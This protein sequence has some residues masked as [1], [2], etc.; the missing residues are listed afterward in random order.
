MKGLVDTYGYNGLSKD[1]FTVSAVDT[2]AFTSQ[3]PAI[4][5]SSSSTR[6]S[7]LPFPPTQ[8]IDNYG[9]YE[10]AYIVQD[11]SQA[12][13]GDILNREIV[14]ITDVQSYLKEELAAAYELISTSNMSHFWEEEA[15]DPQHLSRLVRT[16]DTTA[17]STLRNRFITEIHPDN[18][19]DNTSSEKKIS[20]EPTVVTASFQTPI[21]GATSGLNGS[22]TASLAWCIYLESM[23][24]NE[25]LN[26]DIKE[27][28]GNHPNSAIHA[29]WLP[30]FGPNPSDEAR[31]Q[32][33]DYV[34]LRWPIKVFAIDPVVNEQNISDVRSVYRQMQ[35]AVALSYAQGKVGTSAAMQ[36]MRKLQRDRATVDLNRTAIGFGH[37]DD[38]FGWRF[39]PRFQTMKVEGNAKVLVRDLFIGGPT[40]KQLERTRQI[41]PG[42][43]ECTAIV[44]MPS[45]VPHVT[46]STRGNW[47]KLGCEGRT[48][49]SISDTL[50]YSRAIKHMETSALECI[51]CSH[52]YRDGEIDRLLKR[53][54]QLDRKLPIQTLECQVPIENTHGGFEV[55]T[56]GTRE[57]APKLNGWYGSPGYDPAN[58]TSLFLS[59]DNFSVTST[60]LIIGNQL[61]PFKL[62]SRQVMEVTLP[63]DLAVMKD[64]NLEKAY[65]NNRS[66]DGFIDAQVA[67]PYGV[68]SHLLIPVLK[69]PEE[70]KPAP[71]PTT[72]RPRL[73]GDDITTTVVRTYSKSNMTYTWRFE[74]PQPMTSSI[75]V[76]KIP[77]NMGCLVENSYCTFV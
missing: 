30:Y 21:K 43:R 33:A 17:L 57:L 1:K 38:T 52:L 54:H 6:K 69:G 11:A 50:D 36:A 70:K 44:L 61:I 65:P 26:Q 27:T 42:M 48:A 60:K 76:V 56:S 37:G 28:F 59:G 51:Q 14:H 13:R 22:S 46:F 24:L 77:L 32:F 49:S 16:R 55:F 4:N 35:M 53:V 40:D 63:K 72:F 34:R 74:H 39:Y 29:A 2:S 66:F 31:L 10:L 47:F 25:R 20:I 71:E 62:L 41:E 73:I 8:L 18:A 7:V 12:F 68:S 45:F 58:S 75:A 9:L 19:K 23:L 64:P 15:Q 3:I 5:I 67:S